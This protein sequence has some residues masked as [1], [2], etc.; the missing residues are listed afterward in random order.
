MNKPLFNNVYIDIEKYVKYRKNLKDTFEKFRNEYFKLKEVDIWYKTNFHSY[1]HEL[2]SYELLKNFGHPKKS[3]DKK[4]GADYIINNINI[5]CVVPTF[6]DDSKAETQKLINLPNGMFTYNDYNDKFILRITNS[7]DKKR[8][9]YINLLRNKDIQ[10]ELYFIHIGLNILHQS[11]IMDYKH[12]DLGK[13]FYG[14]GERIIHID[15]KTG[16]YV[17]EDRKRYEN[18]LNSNNSPVP[19]ALFARTEYTFL[20]GVMISYEGIGKKYNDFNTVLFLNPYAKNKPKKNVFRG[21]SR[22]TWQKNSDNSVDIK[23]IPNES[24]KKKQAFLDMINKKWQI[25]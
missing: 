8:K 10:N 5:E 7:L 19:V 11:M 15:K 20:S 4:C 22:W 21:L 13:A 24:H 25:R 2:R 23:F 18:I 9:Q 1:L 3:D 16:A 14:F 12:E 6:G 17:G